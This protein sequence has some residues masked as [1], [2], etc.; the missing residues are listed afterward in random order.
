[1]IRIST[2]LFIALREVHKNN[3]IHRDIK[4]DNIF[5]KSKES[6]FLLLGDFGVSLLYTDEKLPVTRI[7]TEFYIAKELYESS[8][9]PYTNK[10]DIFSLGVVLYELTYGE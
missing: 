8:S 1:M 4:P 7:G 5:I 10:V 9:E 3:I 6:K 2:Q